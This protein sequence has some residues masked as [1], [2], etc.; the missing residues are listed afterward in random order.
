MDGMAYRPQHRV[1]LI[2]I[3]L[4]LLVIVLPVGGF[5]VGGFGWRTRSTAGWRPSA[6]P[7]C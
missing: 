2:V 7:D 1:R 5:L 4:I 6:W 3:S